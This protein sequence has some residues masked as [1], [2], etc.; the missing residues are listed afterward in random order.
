MTGVPMRVGS[1]PVGPGCPALI[2]AEAGV[3]HNGDAGAAVALV[4][5]ARA[6]GADCVKFQT[7]QAERIVTAGAPKADYQLQTTD[8]A[9]SQIAMLR[10]LELPEA[11]YPPL[12]EE[13]GRSGILFLST[14]YSVEDVDL[15]DRLGV[16]AFKVAS[17]QIIEP[18]FLRH[19][20]AK[21][22]PVFLSTGMATLAE[23]DEAVRTIRETGNDQLV[24]LQCTTNYPSRPKDANIL[25]MRTMQAAFGV[26]VGYSD[27]TQSP[28]A[29]IAAVA[30][31]ACVIEKHFTLDRSL[32][33]PDQSSS[34]DPEEFCRLVAAIR[35]TEAVLGT[36][37]KQPVEA[38]RRN[39]SAMR[40]SLVSAVPIPS[41]TVITREMLTCKRPGTGIPPK[42][43]DE[44]VGR[45]AARDIPRDA[46]LA[47]EWLR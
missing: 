16:A 17:G 28:V 45:V 27:H 18:A 20:A 9:E 21:G 29:C 43:L 11:A 15:L 25:A 44:V 19:V 46:L 42:R 8:A 35:E 34:A 22:K 41:G 5:A 36:G 40:R 14:P 24:L 7:F 6:C 30:L 12:L 37:V 47:P 1:R 3:N 23:V 2:I 32:P 31:G 13:C 10:K 39:S 33:G 38:E 26:P 4:R